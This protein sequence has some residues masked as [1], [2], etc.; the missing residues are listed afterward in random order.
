MAVTDGITSATLT[1]VSAALRRGDVSSVEVTRACLDRIEKQQPRLNC[2]AS[3]DGE[4]A[5]AAAEAADRERSAGTRGGPLHGVPLAHKD[6]FYRKGE[7]TDF[8]SK[9][10]KD[11]VADDTSDVMARIDAAGAIDLGPLHMTEFAVGH[12]GAHEHL[13]FCRN[14]WNTDRIPGGSSS[15]SGAAV[16]AR[17]VYG[18]VASDTGGSCRLPASMCGVV[19][20]KP[21]YGL[22]SRFGGMP[23]SWSLDVFGVYARTVDDAGLLLQ[24]IA[25]ES[26]EDPATFGMPEFS[27]EDVKAKDPAT[28][29]IG[30]PVG[31][32]TFEADPE[33][34]KVIDAARAEFESL[35]CDVVE[36]AL[37]GLATIGA[38]GGTILLSEATAI[39]DEWMREIPDQYA[40]AVTWRLQQG[41]YIPATRYLQAL[42][43][44]PR[45]AESFVSEVYDAVDAIFTPTITMPVL[46][47]ATAN[48]FTSAEASQEIFETTKC[49]VWANYLGLPAMS[50]P[51]GFT[52]DGLPVGM[53]LA[54]RPFDEATLLALGSAYQSRTDWH[55]RRPPES[56]EVPV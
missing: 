31:E 15:G 29:K 33:V 49:T 2:F 34:Q 30:V 26:E 43:L 48:S 27:V 44:R 16:A 19:G 4:G 53:Q 45:I 40:E 56:D 23:R 54:A 18:S 1:E 39:H 35:G 46:D 3:F 28:L 11:Y 51:C 52:P 8:G 42:R 10:C 21:T 55:R 38:L 47:F 32:A 20:I 12:T 5:L 13:G 7:V 37:P 6:M 22:V 41:H 24:V 50:V 14:P 17:L 36:I 9:I 25:G